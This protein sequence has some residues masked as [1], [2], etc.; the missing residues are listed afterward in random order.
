MLG[1]KIELTK[2]QMS[3]RADKWLLYFHYL[4]EASFLCI[5]AMFCARYQ[6]HVTQKQSKWEIKLLPALL[7][8]MPNT[9]RY[10]ANIIQDNLP[11]QLSAAESFLRS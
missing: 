3:Q 8:Q 5:V 7:T 1:I 2:S 11:N 4:A 6:M 10:R 9:T